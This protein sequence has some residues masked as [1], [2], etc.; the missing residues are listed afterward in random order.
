MQTQRD[1]PATFDQRLMHGGGDIDDECLEPGTRRDR[2]RSSGG[3]RRDKI[4]AGDDAVL[5]AGQ[6][7]HIQRRG[8]RALIQQPLRVADLTVRH[9]QDPLAVGNVHVSENE[10]SI[11]NAEQIG[12]VGIGRGRHRVCAGNAG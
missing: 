11:Q 12:G 5:L 7:S 3:G 10:F 9:E 1:M 6:P 2:R 4:V 8:N